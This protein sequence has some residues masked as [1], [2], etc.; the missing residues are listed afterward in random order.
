[1]YNSFFGFSESPFSL[2]PDLLVTAYAM[3]QHT[4]SV[5]MLDEVCRDMRLEWP[6]SNRDRREHA[7]YRDAFET[8]FATGD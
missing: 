3:E 1:M 5:A 8:P 2:S 7:S 6:G 4:V